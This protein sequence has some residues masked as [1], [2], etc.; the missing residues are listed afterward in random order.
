MSL[1]ISTNLFKS[2]GR[3]RYGRHVIFLLLVLFPCFLTFSALRHLL[4]LSD[5]SKDY[6]YIL[7]VPIVSTYSLFLEKKNVF[8]ETHFSVSP[9]I[10]LW[11]IGASIYAI[12]KLELIN[13]NLNDNASLIVFS[14]LLMMWGSFIFA[15][16]IEACKSSIFALAFLILMIPIPSRIM[17]ILVYLIRIGSRDIAYQILNILGIP[18]FREGFVFHFAKINIEVTRGC[19]GIRSILGL[20]MTGI[21]VAHFFIQS[22]WKKAGLFLSIVPIILVQN[23]IRIVTLILIALYV[24]EK[25]LTEAS[26]WHSGAGFLHTF[27]G[28]IFYVPGLIIIYL[29]LRSNF[30]RSHSK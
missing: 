18:V 26:F 25:I 21:V 15:Y 13:L 14:A 11:I 22:R 12:G 20:I 23:S 4:A 19:S 7:L 28:I 5:H 24:N 29:I 6:S 1:K 16:G 17:E 27:I 3:F 30:G 10:M 2:H 8:R 9:G